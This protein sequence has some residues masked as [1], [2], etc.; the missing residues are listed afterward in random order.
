MN[1]AKPPINKP[2]L[3]LLYLW[4]II[5]LPKISSSNLLFRI[6]YDLFLFPPDKA[7]EFIKSSIKNN[8]LIFSEENH[9]S[10]SDSLKM[11]LKEWHK[12]RK[13]DILQNITSVEK[14]F[15]LKTNIEQGKS[16]NFSEHLRSLVEKETLNRA[17][18]VSNE[19]FE[20]KEL[21][22]NKGIIK[23]TVSG[24]KE[25]PYIIEIDINNKQIKHDCH[26]FEARRSRNKQFCKHLTKFFLLLR[27]S[28]K[29]PIEKILKT[30]SENLENW[31]FL[32]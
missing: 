2:E 3:L 15:Q 29:V 22:F 1:L 10:L 20:I 27:E 5:D 6:S 13:K 12:C 24:S 19:A 9:L 23:A 14:I 8:F 18:R 32:F 25:D 16:T 31:N 4:K 11:K 30:L 21:D 17:V 7:I 26:D 28:H